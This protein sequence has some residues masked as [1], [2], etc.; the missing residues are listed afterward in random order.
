[1]WFNLAAFTKPANYTFGD[2][3]PGS[4][5]GPSYANLD[6]GLLKDFVI[7]EQKYLQFR[8]EIF[9]S[10]NHTNLGAPSVTLGTTTAGLITAINGNPRNMQLGLKFVF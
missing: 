6:T 9:N 7:R 5:I 2:S 4:I 8:W 1:M 10:L 3:A